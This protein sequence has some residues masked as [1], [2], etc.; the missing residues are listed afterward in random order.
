[1]EPE[2]RQ[3]G[4]LAERVGELRQLVGGHREFR[5]AGQLMIRQF[6]SAFTSGESVY[7]LL[8]NALHLPTPNQ[9]LG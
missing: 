9:I 1:M 6:G 5:Q 7:D 3:A 8:V 4:Q 2:L